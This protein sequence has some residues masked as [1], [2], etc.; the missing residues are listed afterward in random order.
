MG[1]KKI[2]AKYTSKGQRNGMDPAISKAVK[3][4][5][6]VVERMLLKVDAHLNGKKVFA[7]IEN[8]NP[9]ETNKRFIRVSFSNYSHAT[10]N[11]YIIGSKE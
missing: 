3:N 10:K 6:T 5:R 11:G 7:T 1:K 2:R 9:N 4:D 8:P